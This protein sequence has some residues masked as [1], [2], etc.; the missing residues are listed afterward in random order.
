MVVENL[1]NALKDLYPISARV[2]TLTESRIQ[3][4]VSSVIPLSTGHSKG[5]YVFDLNGFNFSLI[6]KHW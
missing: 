3:N 2:K 4:S 1:N 6:I 5:A